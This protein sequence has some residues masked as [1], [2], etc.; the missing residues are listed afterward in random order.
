LLKTGVRRI[1]PAP[2]RI[3]GQLDL[4]HEG[5]T[6]TGRCNCS[7]CKHLLCERIGLSWQHVCW[8]SVPPY[9]KTRATLRIAAPKSG[10]SMPNKEA[11]FCV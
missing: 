9:R 1:P 10:E 6:A 5:A 7:I 8:L 11:L 2:Q 3:E 4:T